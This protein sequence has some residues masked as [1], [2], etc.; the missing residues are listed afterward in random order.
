M[1]T[2]T[3][4]GI[5][6][7]PEDTSTGLYTTQMA[8]YLSKFYNVNVVTGFPYYPQWEI[9]QEYKDLP[10]YYFEEN[11]GIKIYR[12]KQYV[13]KDPSFKKRILHMID[14]TLGSMK[15]SF[16]VQKSDLTICIV[17]FTSSIIL[18]LLVKKFKGGKL[19]VHIQDFEFDAAIES[20]LLSKNSK[21]KKVFANFLFYIETKLLNKANIVS[22]ISYKMIEKL[23]K[24]TSSETFLLPN[25]V[26]GNFINPENFSKHRYLDSS[27]FKI[28]YSGNIGAKQD[29]EFFK[30]F[31]AFLE[32]DGSIEIIVVGDGALKE[33]LIKE[34]TNLKNLRIYDPVP[35]HEL[36]DLLCSADLHILFQKS[37]VID[38]VMPS[39][40]LG[41]MASGKPSL[42][43]G[44]INSE[45]NEIFKKS[46]GEGYFDPSQFQECVNFVYKLKENPSYA[47]EIG[48]KAREF[49]LENYSYEKVL[50]RFRS[51]LEEL[52]K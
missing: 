44:N 40:I 27:K 31:A 38:S 26:D 17:P 33:R 48:F 3:I 41:M 42:V 29:W 34:T 20:G 4:V 19:W 49:I 21:F 32:K 18:G 39:K 24:K 2:I 43:T 37:S 13:P 1:K 47:K 30:K 10:K 22:T 36:S 11:K 23:K 46:Q 52:L 6:F 25:W 51:K 16:K 12:Y 50:D 14:F 35:L 7:Y 9:K 8:E 28:L 45:L 15:N 5:N